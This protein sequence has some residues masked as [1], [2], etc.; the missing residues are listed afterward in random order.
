MGFLIDLLETIDYVK[1]NPTEVQILA[2][3]AILVVLVACG[4]M[5]FRQGRYV[6]LSGGAGVILLLVG[7][8]YVCGRLES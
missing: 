2:M 8:I 1:E 6:W 4:Y 5:A 7:L 3:L